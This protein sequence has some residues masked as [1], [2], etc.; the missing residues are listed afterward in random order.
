[1]KLCPECERLGIKSEWRPPLSEV[2]TAM[3][4]DSYYDRDGLFHEHDPNSRTGRG[5]CSNGHVI[6]IVA[7]RTCGSCNF[8]EGRTTWKVVE[9]R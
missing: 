7:Y 1:M 9:S 8:N 5:Q 3:P 4:R 6:A 2:V